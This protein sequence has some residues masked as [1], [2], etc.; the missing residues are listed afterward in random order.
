[1]KCTLNVIVRDG[2]KDAMQFVKDIDILFFPRP[3]DTFGIRHLSY[4]IRV[5]E[6]YFEIDDGSISVELEVQTLG[7]SWNEELKV[8][9][10]NGWKR[11]GA[12]LGALRK[13]GLMKEVEK[14]EA[15]HRARVKKYQEDP[16]NE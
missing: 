8:F 16:R 12:T 6:S 1:M 5:L 7:E 15:K 4:C 9:L 11:D 10:E 3:G 14:L 2:D 13:A